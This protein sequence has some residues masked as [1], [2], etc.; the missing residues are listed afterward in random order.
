MKRADGCLQF[1]FWDD[2]IDCGTLTNDRAKTEAYCDD[3]IAFLTH[4]LQPELMIP[5]P[6]PGR[7]HNAGTF[8]EIGSAVQMGQSTGKSRD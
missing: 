3:T 8:V 4:Y 5:L 6:A 2:E 7:M 1:F